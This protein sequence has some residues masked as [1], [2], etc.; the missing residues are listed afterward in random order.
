MGIAS[1][2]TSICCVYKEKIK[3]NSSNWRLLSPYKFRKLQPTTQIFQPFIIDNF[4]T[5]LYKSNISKCFLLVSYTLYIKGRLFCHCFQC[6][7]SFMWDRLN[8]YLA[9]KK[10]SLKYI[11]NESSKK[12]YEIPTIFQC[13]EK[14][15]M[16]IC[17]SMY[18]SNVAIF[19]ICLDA[20]FLD[21]NN[22]I[23]SL[24]VLLVFLSHNIC[25]WSKRFLELLR[26]LLWFTLHSEPVKSRLIWV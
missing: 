10:S 12:Y 23:I 17:L 8:Q 24:F 15:S 9:T 11:I 21:T 3:K 4:S 5:H 20:T 1:N 13:V 22:Y 26:L 19:W 7:W 2:F 6:F 25:I 16:L 14:W 18:E